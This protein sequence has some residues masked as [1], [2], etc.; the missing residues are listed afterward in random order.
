MEPI[1]R[2]IE[3]AEVVIQ[4]LNARIQALERYVVDHEQRFDTLQTPL[5][6]RVWFWVDGWP[7]HD[8]N[9]PRRAWRPWHGTCSGCE[10][11]RQRLLALLRWLTGR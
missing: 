11:R 4:S 7:W 1:V 9:A 10:R 5:I 3:E 2:S 6:K 8:L